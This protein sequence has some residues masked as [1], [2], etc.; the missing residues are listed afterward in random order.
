MAKT[1]TLLLVLSLVVYRYCPPGCTATDQVPPPPGGVA[2]L[3]IESAPV[4]ALM[5]KLQTP[6]LPVTT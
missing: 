3:P 6:P 1:E 5:G 4:V 2:Q